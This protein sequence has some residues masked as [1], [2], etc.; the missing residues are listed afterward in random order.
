M[1]WG[2]SLGALVQNGDMMSVSYVG[3]EPGETLTYSAEGEG[4]ASSA[5]IVNGAWYVEKNNTL[6]NPWTLSGSRTIESG[7]TGVYLSI[8]TN[9]ANTRASMKVTCAA[10]APPAPTIS[11]ISPNS[12]SIAGGETVTITGTNFTYATAVIF[13]GATADFTVIS[14]TQ[15]T[16]TTP[17][18][19]A[20]SVNVQVTTADGSDTKTDG[21]TYVAAPTIS[22]IA[23]NSGPTAG[24]SSVTI[25]GTNLS[26]VT[27]VTIGGASAVLGTNSSTSIVITTP[28]GTA[29]ARDVVLTTAGGSVTSTGGFTYVAAPTISTIAPNSGSTG[30]G[31]SVTITGTNLSNVTSVT[32]GGASA[33]LGTN[34][35]TSIVITTPAGTA[36]ARDV[37]LTT[38]GGSVTSTGGFTYIVGPSISTI[39]PNSGPTAGGSSVTIIGTNL[40]GVTGVTVGGAAAVLGTNTANTIIITTPAG[41]AGAADVVLTTAVGSVTSTGGFTYVA[42]PTITGLSPNAGPTAGGSS[43]TISGANLS[44]VT[45]VTIGGAAATLG[46]NSS[47]SIV[48]T[49]P[50]G[51]AG[52]ADVVVT[53]AGGSVT[54]TGGFT[55]IV[56]PSIS[57]IAPNTGPAAGGTTVTIT[58]TN[59]SGVTGVTIGGAAATLGANT[60]T[61][62]IITTPAGTAGARDVVLTTA[63]GSVTST[64]GFTYEAPAPTVTSLSPNSGGIAGGTSVTITGT[65]FT[66]ATAVTFG[67]TAA[68]NVIV[69]N[70]TTITATTPAHAAGSVDVA[71]TTPGGTGSKTGGFTYTNVVPRPDP[72]RDAEVIGLLNAQ[73]GAAARVAKNQMRNFHGR[74][75][76]LHNEGDRRAS[77]MNIRFGFAQ[78]PDSRTTERDIWQ[79]IDN[80][81]GVAQNLRGNTRTG[82]FSDVPG[83]APGYAPGTAALGYAPAARST[84]SPS[85]SPGTEKPSS[86]SLSSLSDSPFAAWSGGFVNFGKRDQGGID[87]DYTMVGVSGGIDYRFSDKFVAGIGVGYGRD[88]T[89]VGKNGT[90]NR[91]SAFSGA[92][93][94]SYKPIDNL[95][96]DGVF[97]GSWMDMD[98]RRFVTANGEFAAGSRNG[99]QIFGALTAAYEFRDQKWLVS[100]YGRFE[101]SRAWLDNLVETGGGI[102][103]LTYGEQT[104]DTLSG[105]LGIRANYAFLMDWG[106]LKPGI[107]VE[108]TH[109]F[110]GSSRASL[111]YADLGGLPYF[112]DVDPSAR[113]YVTLGLSLDMA[114]GN[115]WSL[116][117]D[118]R[119]SFG[120]SGNMDHTTG[121]KLGVRF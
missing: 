6:A 93:Y 9:G 84:S 54:S 59:L 39:S 115:D 7:S 50:A 2:S 85:R 100:P 70:A 44:N 16:A 118:Y 75:E 20:G 48:I 76:Q 23:P 41:T 120:G 111:G 13:G 14:D 60:P 116:G 57:T 36:G 24:G 71:V 42:A 12:G 4:D 119:T 11:T 88:R 55:Y 94:G 99:N 43:V 81:Q 31:S 28:A 73:A 121:A 33:T 53:T 105:V 103:A 87:L 65:N 49:T 27:G 82:A 34:T 52:A 26:G 107:R 67:G 104:I 98:S 117:F 21:F 62:I 40:S 64:G 112:V 45:S 38:A 72:S 15:I 56:G 113:D 10:A 96:I 109:D 74:L 66:G 86:D 47:T 97:G 3:L 8:T 58:G 92:V 18:Y 51:T 90:E 1:A 37:V 17:A 63:G 77:S 80:N 110:A 68:T 25:T 78:D 83:T 5:L 29:G 106:I 35:A 79:A 91:T 19:S 61:S 30:G 89:D 69:V 95:F 101:F 108:Y 22:T 114:F 32:V 46:T 102:Y